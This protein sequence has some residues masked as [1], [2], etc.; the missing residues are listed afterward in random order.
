MP[1][2]FRIL[3]AAAAG[4]VPAG[5]EGPAETRSLEVADGVAE[6]RIGRRAGL[7][8]SL[9]FPALSAVHALIQA[10]AGGWV[11]EDLR[12]TNG[13]WLGDQ[14]LAPGVPQPLATGARLMLAHV[15]LVF[16]GPAAAA[17]PG[18][19]E[20]TGTIAR[21]L[22][23]DL[24]AASPG[25][26][27]PQL[28]VTGGAAQGRQLALRQVDRRYLV[29]RDDDCDLPLA[30]EEVSR[31]HAAFTRRWEGVFV[32]DLG[33][34]NGVRVAGAPIAGEHRLTDGD[35]VDIGPISLQ[36][37]DPADRYLNELAQLADPPPPPPA[38]PAP[39]PAA[40]AVPPPVPPLPLRSARLPLI[41]AAVALLAVL[42]A[43]VALALTG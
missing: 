41:V 14:R 20:G 34:K 29:G 17:T 38:T 19:A 40:P 10:R 24:F 39:L 25:G 7:E 23:N 12:S 33:S 9:P 27:A 5:A 22:V 3:A 15:V 6:I 18:A 28:E 21:R 36:F 31:E 1:V 26:A 2:R 11:V 16:D 4:P 13:T 43:A 42:A 30:L 32:R 37:R 35:V 8:V